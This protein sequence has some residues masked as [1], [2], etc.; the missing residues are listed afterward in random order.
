MDQDV[1]V[2]VYGINKVSHLLQVDP[3]FRERMA[4]DA[5]EA[6]AAMPLNVEERTA[7]LDGDVATL[8]RLGA[9]TFLL[10]RIPRFVPG[11]VDRD[12]YIE[13]MRTLL[14]ADERAAVEAASA[15]ATR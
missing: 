6:I 9:H 5:S 4:L 10:S 1:T 13:R 7:I 3:S 14:T 12:T 11:L 2:S 15:R 8:C